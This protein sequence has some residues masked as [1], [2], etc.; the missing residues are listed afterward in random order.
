[1][2]YGNFSKP[3]K[4]RLLEHSSR[5]LSR[6]V[7]M[8]PSVL[9]LFVI[10]SASKLELCHSPSFLVIHVMPLA[11][12]ILGSREKVTRLTV[13]GNEQKKYKMPQKTFTRSAKLSRPAN[14][15]E[16]QNENT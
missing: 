13:S 8:P 1:M 9:G 10:I 3:E 4:C 7:E 11:R 14:S 2:T 16:G 6:I 12:L 15:P 5:L